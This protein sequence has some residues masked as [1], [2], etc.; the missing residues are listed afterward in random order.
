MTPEELKNIVRCV[1]HFYDENADDSNWA[2]MNEACGEVIK[3]LEQEPCEDAVSRSEVVE[4]LRRAS[5]DS[6]QHAID[7]NLEFIPPVTP[8]LPECKDAVSRIEVDRLCYRYLKVATDEHVAFYEHFLDLPS[9]E[10]AR[11]VG[12]W[13]TDSSSG[14]CYCSKCGFGKSQLSNKYCAAC[15]AEMRDD[16]NESQGD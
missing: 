5:D 10:P 15:G 11:R 16:E 13:I 7:S 8:K 14:M 2:H 6:I 3:I 12:K 1:F 9:V 4:W